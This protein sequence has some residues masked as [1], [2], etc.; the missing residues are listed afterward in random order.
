MMVPHE[1]DSLAPSSATGAARPER[2]FGRSI[3][4]R[5]ASQRPG[6]LALS[7]ITGFI[8][9]L[10]Y[11]SFV[12]HDTPRDLANFLR[13]GLHGVGLAAAV[14]AVQIMFASNARSS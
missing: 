11:R 8:A 14:W 5:S 3:F 13:S 1:K 2:G 12:N 9:G 7:L 10:A 6:L 4:V